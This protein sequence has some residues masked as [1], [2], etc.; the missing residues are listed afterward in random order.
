MI[1]AALAGHAP[2][3]LAELNATAA[4]QTRRDRKY[5]LTQDGRQGRP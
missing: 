4:L 2:V 5:V 1:A 3:D